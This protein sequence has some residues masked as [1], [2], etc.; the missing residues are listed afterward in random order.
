M[1]DYEDFAGHVGSQFTLIDDGGGA[2]IELVLE[3][4]NAAQARPMSV[5]PSTTP[6]RIPPVAANPFRRPFSLIFFAADDHVLPQRTYDLR[7]PVLGERAI[8]L[9]PIAKTVRGVSYEAAFG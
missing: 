5:T 6:S 7:H 9:V 1:F 4:A 8:F 3:E 2:S